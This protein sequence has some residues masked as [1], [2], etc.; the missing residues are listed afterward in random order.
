MLV[1]YS[2]DVLIKRLPIGNLLLLLACIGTFGLQ[3]AGVV[4]INPAHPLVLHGWSPLGLVGHVFL[5]AGF[6]HLFFNMLYLWVFGNAVCEKIG[7]LRHLAVFLLCGVIAGAI[8]NVLDGTPAI[9]ASGAL[10]G[11]IGFYL[12]LYPVN[13]VHCF[14]WVLRP[15]S[16]SL[17]GFWLILFWFVV[18]AWCAFSGTRNGIA[19]WAHVGGFL[20]GFWLAVLFLKVGWARMASYDNPTLVDVLRPHPKPP[21]RSRPAAAVEPACDFNLD[22]PHCGRNLDVPAAVAARP[23]ACPVCGGAISLRDR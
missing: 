12:V 5:H 9:G 1:P 23:F 3:V 13:R 17:S 11:L 19:Y 20:T 7:S 22:C 15:G 16:V 14:Y 10:N 2:T 21:P 8:H 6:F 18:D 4:E